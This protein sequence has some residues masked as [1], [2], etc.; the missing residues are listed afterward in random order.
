MPKNR[1]LASTQ[2]L[3]CNPEHI[4][5]QSARLVREIADRD[6]EVARFLASGTRRYMACRLGGDCYCGKP[7]EE[8]ETVKAEGSLLAALTLCLTHWLVMEHDGRAKAI[9]QIRQQWPE[10]LLVS[11][12]VAAE[13]GASPEALALLNDLLSTAAS[14]PTK[15]GSAS[16]VL[17]DT[18]S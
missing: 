3:T 10:G 16:A 7:L 5:S 15:D 2:S 4:N 1:T 14:S 13:C 18:V 11:D 6:P 12:S 9:A 17:Q 8:R